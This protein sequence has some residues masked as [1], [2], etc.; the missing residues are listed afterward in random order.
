LSTLGKGVSKDQIEDIILQS[1]GDDKGNIDYKDFAK[2]LA[3]RGEDNKLIIPPPKTVEALTNEA[4]LVE[5]VTDEAALVE[6]VTDEAALVEA[7]TDE[8]ALVEAVT[9]EAALVEA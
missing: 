2:R 9:D 3:A 1:K 7:V 8:A 5:A 4:A 6:A